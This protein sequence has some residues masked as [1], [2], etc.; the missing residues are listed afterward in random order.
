MA[1]VLDQRTLADPGI[2]LAQSHALRLGQPHQALSGAV[3]E[4]GVGRQ[5]DRLLLDRG[6]HDHLAEVGRLGRTRAGGHGQAL[7][8]QRHQAFLAHSLRPARHRGAVKGER[9]AEE[10]L[11]AEELEIGVLHPSRTERLVREVVHVLEDGQAGHE[12]G[13]QG[14]AAGILVVD[15][16]ELLLEEGPVGDVSEP[17]EGVLEVDDLIEPG[18]E[19]IGLSAV[20]PFLGSHVNPRLQADEG[21]ITPGRVDQFARKGVHK[22]L[23][24]AN[25]NTCSEPKLTSDQRLASSSRTTCERLHTRGAFLTDTCRPRVNWLTGRNSPM[26]SRSQARPPAHAAG[27]NRNALPAGL[28]R[29]SGRTG[30]LP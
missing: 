3:Q 25:M 14:R 7:L 21:G 22:L 24:S 26:P 23:K 17:D 9:V 2:G 13:G 5:R 18:A 29:T 20:A 15:G 10:F 27:E 30:R 19:E 6:I 28:F 11:G 4:L 12:A 8:Q 16:A 1:L